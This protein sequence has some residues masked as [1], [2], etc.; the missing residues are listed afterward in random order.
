MTTIT[1]NNS[2]VQ[3]N[4][5][6]SQ[7]KAF[8]ICIQ[9]KTDQQIKL[10]FDENLD[11]ES[12]VINIDKILEWTTDNFENFPNDELTKRTHGLD[13]DTNFTYYAIINPETNDW[14]FYDMNKLRVRMREERLAREQE[15]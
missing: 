15:N 6:D 1:G 14:E 8:S 10:L 2:P 3:V 11:P 5:H 7:S 13:P 12:W 4:K 9:T